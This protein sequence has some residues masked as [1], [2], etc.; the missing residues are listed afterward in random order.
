MPTS[1][2]D[3]LERLS[4]PAVAVPLLLFVLFSVYNRLT[5]VSNIPERVPWIGKDTSKI[6]ASTRA[7]IAGFNNARKWLE[8]GYDKVFLHFL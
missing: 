8:D 3:F 7:S 6:F 1:M 4:T 2:D 5:T